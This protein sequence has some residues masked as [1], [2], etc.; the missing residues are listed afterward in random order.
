MSRTK[1]LVI[2]IALLIPTASLAQ[3]NINIDYV[4]K[5]VVFLYG[6]DSAGNID[7]NKPIGT[8]FIVQVP[9]TLDGTKAWKLLVTA[10]HIAD[11]QWAHCG[12]AT[13]I[14]V[15][16]NKKNFDASKDAVG[17][18][19]L[20]LDVDVA[21]GRGWVFSDDAEIDAAVIP[22]NGKMLDD[23]EVDGVRI[24]DFPTPEEQ[25]SFRSGDEI[26]SAGLL[27]GAS[28]KKRNYPIFKF[29]N[30]SSIPEES[31]DIPKCSQ[32]PPPPHGLKV[33][34]IAASLVPGNSGSPIFYV[35]SRFST[36]GTT[37]RPVL[38][39]VQSLSYLGWDV[40]GMTPA[41]Y[42]YEIIEKVKL[43]GADLRRNIPPA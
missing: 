34:F 23:Y 12:V 29:G 26:V 41:E 3:P 14:F 4:R 25:K 7:Q 32:D 9:Q 30:V 21:G 18:T 37:S 17:T 20:P 42:I 13:K 19:D 43:P 8:G 15:R 1:L 6:A 38:L 36:P 5:S 40:A 33:W 39:G 35:P 11:P 2:V 10:R 24:G 31:A 16:V 22:L 27:P 28:G